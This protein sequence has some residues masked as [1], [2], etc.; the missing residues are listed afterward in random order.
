MTSGILV[1]DTMRGQSYFLLA[2]LLLV[3][4]TPFVE[5]V[6]STSARSQPCSGAICINEALPNPNGLDDAMY[7]GGEWLEI[8]NSGSTSVD[9]R[10]WYFSNK[11]S[12]TLTFDVNSIVGYDI[13]NASTYTIAPGE[14]MVIARN[15]YTN[16]YVANSND[17]MTL[18]DGSGNWIDEATW[19]SSSSGVS[20]EQDPSDPYADWI[21]TSNPTPGSSNSGGGSAGPTYFPS[22]LQIN[23]VM[24]DSWPSRDNTSWPGGEW[25][26]LH[27]NGTTTINMSGWWL[28]D[29]A[30]NMIELDSSHLIGA[31]SDYATQLIYPGEIRT[32]AVNATSS[33]GVLNNGQETVRLYLPNG[34]IG[35]EVS[36]NKNEPGFSLEENPLGG[37]W[38]IST[39]PSPNSTNIP[40]LASITASGS[41]GF[42]EIMPVSNNDGNASPL[43]E[44]IE[45]LNTGTSDIDLNGWSIIDGMGNQ[46]F[47]DPGTIAVNSSQG[48]TTILSGERRIV[49]FTADTRLWDN[50]NH[51]VLLDASSNVVDMAWYATNYGPNISLLRSYQLQRCMVAI[52]LSYS[53]TTRTGSNGNNR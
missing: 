19:N 42:N 30:G 10:N 49:E 11:A 21:A 26:E 45:L 29:Q 44:W 14:Y 9:V 40:T 27:N 35:D 47:L 6:E 17:F 38:V 15:G 37:M 36:W 18:Y 50:Y 16:F 7:P 4:L 33:S 32:V 48:S 2:L 3:P 24:A 31:T 51:L 20:L 28:Q 22:D 39:Y 41:V 53:W 52:P 34:S 25:I 43:G 13:N 5:P 23:E 12:K 46:T 1:G 8:Y